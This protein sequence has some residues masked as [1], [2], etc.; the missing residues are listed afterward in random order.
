[1]AATGDRPTVRTPTGDR[2]PQGPPPA[3]RWAAPS[4]TWP[5]SGTQGA[6][7]D[8]VAPAAACLGPKCAAAEDVGEKAHSMQEQ[9]HALERED[10][11]RGDSPTQAPAHA[12]TAMKP[13]AVTLATPETLQSGA[14][15]NSL[16]A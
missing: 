8:Q 2:W 1:M 5:S 15:L 14:V 13:L 10:Q 11:A 7:N 16:D 3:G 9:N 12:R 4:H 6:A